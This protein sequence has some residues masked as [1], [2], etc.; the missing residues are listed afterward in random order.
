M[1]LSS[2]LKCKMMLELV[3]NSSTMH[4]ITN[5]IVNLRICKIKIVGK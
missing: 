5:I 2:T 4:N 3:I 1:I